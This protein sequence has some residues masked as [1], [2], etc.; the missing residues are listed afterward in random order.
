MSP[1]YVDRVITSWTNGRKACVLL[2]QNRNGEKYLIKRYHRRFLPT[3]IREALCLRYL[4]SRLGCVPVLL[5]ISLL[6]NE[7]VI[8]YISGERLLEW[9]LKR[10]GPADVELQRFQSFHG[11]KTNPVVQTAL[12]RFRA[13]SDGEIMNLK[14]AIQESYAEL[15]SLGWIHG[16]ADPRNL[17]YDGRRVFLIDFD[18]ARP[19]SNAFRKEAP[20]LERWFGISAATEPDQALGR[21]VSAD[22]K[23]S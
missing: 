20:G 21:S 11:L 12:D 6:R 3:M 17:I 10:L 18:H 15:H 22:Y 5:R 14:A 7:L 9:I 1:K 23:L 16:S 8:S 4:A 13:S 2:M 19:C